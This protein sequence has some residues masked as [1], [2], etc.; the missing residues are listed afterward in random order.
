[1]NNF[2]TKK[3]LGQHFLINKQI[4][5]DIIHNCPNI[6]DY[7]VIEVGPG[8]LALT[9]ELVLKA[10]QV[11][12]IEKD[13]TLSA[14]LEA[15]K[16]KHSNFDYKI[17]DAMDIRNIPQIT[18]KK[19]L[20]SNLP[21]NVGT[22]IYLN[23]L[24]YAFENQ[25]AFDYFV[26]MFQKEVALR[27]CAEPRDNNYGRL[28]IISN[29]LADVE[30]LFDVDKDNFNPPPKIMSSV[31]RVFVNKEKRYNIDIKKLESLTNIAFSGRRKT[32]KNSLKSLNINW[33]SLSIDSNKRA[34]ELSL[35]DYSMILSHIGEN[36]NG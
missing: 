16:N 24:F 15:F 22:Q 4:I 32:I 28:S 23:Y 30:F 6:Q 14:K 20:V 10:K 12:A 13:E 2:Y 21:Y 34:E 19:I 26:L 17:A 36:N 27:I 8:D 1:M 18:G 9:N 3:H 29:L 7:T 11:F 33:D 31:I 35:Q 25:G 5:D